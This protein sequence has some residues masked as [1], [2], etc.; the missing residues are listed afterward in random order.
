MSS[1]PVPRA[2]CGPA[3]SSPRLNQQPHE[4]SDRHFRPAPAT[5]LVVKC[6]WAAS[7]RI[8]LQ[9]VERR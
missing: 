2:L 8:C 6:P 3:D 4:V 1:A 5:R 7:S 9:S